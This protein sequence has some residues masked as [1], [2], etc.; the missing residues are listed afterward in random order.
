MRWAA[1]M[2]G[3]GEFGGEVAV[4]AGGDGV[5]GGRAVLK[6]EFVLFFD[7]GEPA[8]AG[9]EGDTD[10]ALGFDIFRVEGELGLSE[11]FAAGDEGEGDEAWDATEFNRIENGGRIEI[12]D[13]AGDGG[14]EAGGVEVG[15]EGR[16]AGMAGETGGEVV[17]GADGVW[18]DDADAGDDDAGRWGGVGD[19]EF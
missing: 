2:E 9:A 12:T 3:D 19:R 14:T 1:E 4:G 16:E 13:L 8:A 11:G 6:E 17:G 18:A 10:L 15:G 7:E 5:E